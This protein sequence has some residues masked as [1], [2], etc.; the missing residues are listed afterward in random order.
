MAISFERSLAITRPLRHRSCPKNFFYA[1]LVVA[2]L[3]GL[4]TSGLIVADFSLFWIQYRAIVV[5]VAG[6][7]F[8]LLTI[9]IMYAMT[10]KSVKSYVKRRRSNSAGNLQKYLHREKRTAV[11]VVFVLVAFIL[12]WLPFFIVSLVAVFC[13]VCGQAIFGFTPIINFVKI[14]HYTNSAVNPFIYTFRNAK[15]K[16]EFLR[17]VLPCM[18]IPDE[19]FLRA[20]PRST[21]KEY[22]KQK[23]SSV[24]R[25]SNDGK[26]RNSADVQIHNDQSRI[27]L[28]KM[29]R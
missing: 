19:K 3:Y 23:K 21:V 18:K 22:G 16:R 28:L 8:P 5:F 1:L 15:W 13:L 11:T 26:S 27:S 4:L 25:S 14:L 20:H 10:Y 7:C 9:I 29:N 6:F 12:A 2:W 24:S 17:V